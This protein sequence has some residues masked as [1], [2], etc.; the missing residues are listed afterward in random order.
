MLFL[1]AVCR[2]FSYGDHCRYRDAPRWAELSLR[3]IRWRR[4]GCAR[5]L[6]QPSLCHNQA[7]KL[8]NRGLAKVFIALELHAREVRFSVTIGPQ[9]VFTEIAVFRQT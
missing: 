8:N 7:E 3:S 4:S 1:C 9:G 5:R 2:H 6:G